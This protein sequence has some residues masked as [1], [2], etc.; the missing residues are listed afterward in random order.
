MRPGCINYLV[1]LTLV[2]LC[3]NYR[4]DNGQTPFRKPMN[5]FYMLTS[6]GVK[7]LGILI[8]THQTNLRS[9][10]YTDGCLLL[11]G[12]QPKRLLPMKNLSGPL[13]PW[14]LISLLGWMESTL[15]YCNGG[16]STS[17]HPWYI[18]LEHLSPWDIYLVYGDLPGLSSFPN[19]ESLTMLLLKHSDQSASPPSC[20]RG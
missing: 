13:I 20:W 11:T 8:L 7:L 5:I 12:V 4:A 3:Y 16:L 2:L 19:R 18:S 1:S 17:V 14:P 9:H 6:Q 15:Y 10:L